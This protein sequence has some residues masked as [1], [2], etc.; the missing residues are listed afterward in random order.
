MRVVR[1]ILAGFGILIVLAVVGLVFALRYTADCPGTPPPPAGVTLMA[2]TV[3]RC[4][5]GPEVL[6][7]EHVPRPQLAPDEVLVH[8]RAVSLNPL[9][10]HSMRGTPY[11]VRLDSGI[12]KPTAPQLGVDFAGTVEAVGGAVRRFK[13]G[14]EVFGGRFGAFA[15]YVKVKETRGITLKPA[16]VSFEQAAA[17]AIAAVTALQGL[18]DAGQLRAGQKVLIN[19]ASG[20][21]GTYAVQIAK[22][23]GAQ[24]T[25]V[26]SARN[27]QMVRAL[28]AAEVIDYAREDF[29]QGTA[30][31]D[32]IF[33]T[34]STHSLSQYAR[35]LSPAGRVVIVGNAHL[36]DWL[37]PFVTPLMAVVRSKFSRQQFVPIFAE[38][39]Q[40]DLAQLAQLMQSHQ[41]TSVIDRTLPF[42]QLPQGMRYLEAGHAHGKVVI[43]AP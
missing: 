14:D 23:Y 34:V 3:H 39:R 22:S 21:V 31:Y 27:A 19:G 10:L 13:V 36:G 33:D 32:L 20:G 25:G 15:E 29:T 6:H 38:L 2:A 16:E 35:V 43:E 42:E 12:G 1:L 4:Y 18:R 24:V 37:S 30:R 11:L 26:C 17:V 40:E 8:V 41:L 5:G 7:L 28:G 9:D